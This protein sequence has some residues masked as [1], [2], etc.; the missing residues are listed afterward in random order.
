MSVNKVI[1]LGNLGKDP[2]VRK[3]EN[4]RSVAQFSL[5]TN[6]KYKDKAGVLQ[7]KTE[8][9]NIVAWT[10]LAEIAEKYLKKGGQ[11]YIEGKI[12]SREYTDK[13]GVNRR[14]T[15]VVARE[16][17]LIGG[18]GGSGSGEANSGASSKSELAEPVAASADD[19][20]PF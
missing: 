11:V 9:H 17:T 2:L 19:D 12:E 18:A 5:A 16:L 10:P 6:E 1:L 3:L 15:E 8:W 13:E 7:T 4:G 14:T 20:L